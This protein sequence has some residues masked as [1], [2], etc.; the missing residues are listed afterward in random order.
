MGVLA[1][2]RHLLACPSLREVAVKASRLKSL[3]IAAIMALSGNEE[4]TRADTAVA[5]VLQVLQ[6][7]GVDITSAGSLD[8]MSTPL[9]EAVCHSL[10]GAARVLLDAGADVNG[11]SLEGG[12]GLLSAAAAVGSDASMTWLLEHGASLTLVTADGR[13][14][15]HVLAAAKCAPSA[16]NDAESADFCCR[17]LRRVV[18]AEPSLLEARD[19]NGDSHLMAPAAAGSEACVAALLEL[20]A[21]VAA[22]NA[23]GWTALA[24]ACGS[25]SLPVVRQ[26]IAAGA[27]SA[28]ALPLGSPQARVVAH[29]ATWA[30]LRSEPGCGTCAGRCGGLSR[31]NC[32]DGLDILRVRE[33]VFVGGTSMAAWTVSLTHRKDEASRKDEDTRISAEHALTVLQALHA[34]GVDVLARGPADALPI[35]RQAAAAA[36]APAV[37]RWLVA[38][39]GASLEE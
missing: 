4:L 26:L 3:A 11:C 18:A 15:A 23:D 31:G 5:A 39:V 29:C 22:T 6:E 24:C 37:V 13:N 9:L 16:G 10:L 28:A 19:R 20:G 8:V 36:D 17:W 14:I 7:T 1:T 33:A 12:L 35:L 38:E 21:D 2:L 27:A 25:I 34:A 32:A 30:A